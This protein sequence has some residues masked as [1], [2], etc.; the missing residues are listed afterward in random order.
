MNIDNRKDLQQIAIDHSADI[1]YKDF[2]KI[3]RNC[4]KE[5]YSFLTIDV[6]HPTMK[7]RA[8]Q[9]QYDLDREAANISALSGGEI[10]K[11][12]YLTGEDLGYKPDVIQKPKFE[13]SP[14]GKVFNI[15]WDE[16]DKKEGLLKRLK[17][18]EDQSKINEENKDNQLGIK[19]IRYAVKEELSQKAKNML[20]KLNSEENFIDYRKLNF[21]GGNNIDY[22]F[23]HF[24]LLREFFR[25]IYYGETTSRRETRWFW[26]HA[27]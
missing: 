11:Y 9:A 21:R 7:I 27:W 8:N 25:V 3:Y 23:S 19:S 1:D 14:L 2:L 15:E 6:R 17:N 16:S 5:P 4:T 22:D 12:E 20:D 13:Y 26:L 10:E 18:I 24:R